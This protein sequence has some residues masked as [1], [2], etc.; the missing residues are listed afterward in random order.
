MLFFQE[1]KI[2]VAEGAVVFK[3]QR[4]CPSQSNVESD[5]LDDKREEMVEDTLKYSNPVLERA[6]DVDGPPFPLPF[7]NFPYSFLEQANNTYNDSL[8]APIDCC[9]LVL[10]FR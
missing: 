8:P 3:F 1:T 4:V 9:K 6:H 7:S 2:N 10:T 5:V